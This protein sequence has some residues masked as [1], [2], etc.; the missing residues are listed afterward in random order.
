MLI[1][2]FMHESFS[3]KKRKANWLTVSQ[4]LCYIKIH[5]ISLA[6]QAVFQ[7]VYRAQSVI[8]FSQDLVIF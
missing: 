4:L 8:Y 2:F 3:V 7:D 6:K 5:W 1:S